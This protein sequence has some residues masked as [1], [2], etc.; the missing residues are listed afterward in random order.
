VRNPDS[1]SADNEF[2]YVNDIAIIPEPG[3]LRLLFIR[4]RPEERDAG[5]P[6]APSEV[7]VRLILPPLA[8][9]RLLRML[10]ERLER[11]EA[12]AEEYARETALAASKKNSESDP[13]LATLTAAEDDDD[14]YTDAQRATAH[15][16]WEAFERGETIS[17][18]EVRRE[19][20]VID[21]PG[22]ASPS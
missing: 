11:Q 8:A 2:A 1:G 5:A 9:R 4:S 15:A 17:W 19:L 3:G 13:F 12:L 18:E 10:P 22:S 21:A 14:P 6:G 20:Q 16:G 7:I